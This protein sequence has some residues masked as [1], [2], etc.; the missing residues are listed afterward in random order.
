MP[1]SWRQAERLRIQ[2]KYMSAAERFYNTNRLPKLSRFAKPL[3]GGAASLFAIGS[4]VEKGFGHASRI[5]K[6]LRSRRSGID[7]SKYTEMKRRNFM[8]GGSRKRARVY[9]DPASY[10]QLSSTYV[11]SGRR[12]SNRSRNAKLWRA[13]T[14]GVRFRHSL[15]SDM[16]AANG[17]VVLRHGPVDEPATNTFM[18]VRIFNL[19][20]INQGAA[21]DGSVNA[22]FGSYYLQM[23]TSTGNLVWAAQP[24]TA[25]D[26]TTSRASYEQIM[27]EDSITLGRRALKDW[28]RAK[29]C[30]YGKTKAPST[31]RISMIRFLDPELCPEYNLD[32][33]IGV[34][35]NVPQKALEFWQSRLKPLI[36]GAVADHPK[37]YGTGPLMKVLKRW[38]FNINPID[39][40]AETAAS[41]PR[42]HMKHVDI[43]NRWNRIV[44]FTVP[45]GTNNDTYSSLNNPNNTVVP[46][47]GFSAYL[48]HP[49]QSI[50]LLIESI[51]ENTVAFNASNATMAETQ[52]TMDFNIQTK[53]STIQ[54]FV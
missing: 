49:E 46:E 51:T 27:G 40:A 43:F 52:V 48:R 3:A 28:T 5:Y 7:K 10:K 1:I 47:A 6:R 13:L 34:S 17:A 31:V 15:I 20:N 37:L 36:N 11:K 42:G 50:Y 30:I 41:D 26:G 12:A 14:T 53:Y 2:P 33:S 19:S 25:A 23:V 38:V 9:N 16:S 44:N 4:L 45:V 21:A 35:G 54:P 22:G 8:P 29:L 39:A 24:G 18:P 32:K